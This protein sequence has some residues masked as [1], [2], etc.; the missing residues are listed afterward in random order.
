[1]P[2][3]P[4]EFL[5]FKGDMMHSAEWNSSVSLDN[6]VVGIV[7]SGASAIQI[8]PSIARQV[9][10]LRVYQRHLRTQLNIVD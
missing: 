7:G 8:I 1:V 5:S 2:K 10:E 9:K 3:I 4:E 6:K